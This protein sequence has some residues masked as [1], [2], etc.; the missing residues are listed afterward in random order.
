MAPPRGGDTQNKQGGEEG[1]ANWSKEA[2]L[3]FCDLCS[4]HVEKSKELEYKMDWLFGGSVAIGEGIM[5]PNMD[6]P[7]DHTQEDRQEA[8]IPSPP[9]NESIHDLAFTVEDNCE[10]IDANLGMGASAWQELWR[11]SSPIATPSPTQMAQND[12]GQVRGKRPFEG[13]VSG[14]N[15]SAKTEG[16]KKMGS[17]AMLCEKLDTLLESINERNKRKACAV[18]SAPS[19]ADALAKLLTFYLETSLFSFACALMED[20]R[21]RITLNCL[22]TDRAISWLRYLYDEHNKK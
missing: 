16:G 13:N 7:S 14:A 22:P 9:N 17:A 5:T 15:K 11:E 8:H 10:T 20:P 18:E 3:I 6:P 1:R 4:E 12:G 2:L 21:K 19:L